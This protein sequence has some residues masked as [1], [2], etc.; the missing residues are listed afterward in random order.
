ML[1]IPIRTFSEWED[2]GIGTLGIDPGGPEDATAQAGGSRVGLAQACRTSTLF[3]RSA[4]HHD[5]I[6]VLPGWDAGVTSATTG[7]AVQV[8]TGALD[9]LSIKMLELGPDTRISF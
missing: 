7:P 1:Q 6:R 3:G 5:P 8:A 2:V 9:Q 4:Q